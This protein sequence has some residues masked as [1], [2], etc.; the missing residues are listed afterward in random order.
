MHAILS[1]QLFVKACIFVFLYS[2][3]ELFLN[4]MYIFWLTLPVRCVCVLWDP[5]FWRINKILLFNAGGAAGR[6][7]KPEV[8]LV[9]FR[10]GELWPQA[11]A[12]WKW[13]LGETTWIVEEI[14]FIK[15]GV[16]RVFVFRVFA[17]LGLIKSTYRT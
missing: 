9:C 11:C 2:T 4:Q 16:G 17:W 5:L 10:W 7:L 12:R 1:N 13:K 8:G 14:L 15:V 6:K 3:Y